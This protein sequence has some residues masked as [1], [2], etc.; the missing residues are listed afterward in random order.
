MLSDED[1]VPS[2]RC[3][4]TI[5]LWEIKGK[6]GIYKLKCMLFDGF[7][8]FCGYVFTIFLKQFEFG[9]EFGLFER[10]EFA[11]NNPFRCDHFHKN[12]EK[13]CFKIQNAA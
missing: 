1:R 12:Q 7:E 13:K 5:I 11:G 2:H 4:F 8:T 9:S 6:P 10:G 3:L